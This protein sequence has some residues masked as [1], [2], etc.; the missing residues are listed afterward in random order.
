MEHQKRVISPYFQNK[1]G[2]KDFRDVSRDFLCQRRT[3]DE[4]L[5]VEEDSCRIRKV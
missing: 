1:R 5:K 3:F 4:N 2:R